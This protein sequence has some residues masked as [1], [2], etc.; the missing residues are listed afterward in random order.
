[1]EAECI[2]INEIQITLKKAKLQFAVFYVLAKARID[3]DAHSTS[4]SLTID[5]IMDELNKMGM[6][7][8]DEVLIRQA[9]YYLRRKFNK[10]CGNN[11]GNEIIE[12]T[13]DGGYQIGSKV[14]LI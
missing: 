12:S 5:Q 13:K 7:V 4:R 11:A 10:N 8:F 1:M 9:I 14:A 6:D 2:Y 3:G